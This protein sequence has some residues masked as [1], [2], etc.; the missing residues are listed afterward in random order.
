MTHAAPLTGRAP[1]VAPDGGGGRWLGAGSVLL[2]MSLSNAP[3]IAI[4]M[5]TIG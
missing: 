2:R 4:L 5:D 1:A 3:S